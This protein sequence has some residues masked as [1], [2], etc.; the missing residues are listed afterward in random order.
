MKN[1]SLK[2]ALTLSVA[3]LVLTSAFAA[4]EKP[5]KRERSTITSMTAKVEA[6]DKDKREITLKGSSG[7]TI[8]LGVD[9]SV[10]R[11]DEIKVGDSVT[12]DYYVSIA[13]EVREP[14][15]EEKKTPYQELTS[16]GRTPEGTDP[17]AGSFRIIKAV[18][19]VEGLDRPTKSITVK[20]PK[21]NY[22]QVELKDPSILEKLHL[23]DTIMVTYSEG[24]VISL[25][26]APEKDTKD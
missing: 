15:A 1:N 7:N 4:D 9:K 6:V 16:T 14:T 10:K 11:F 3:T 20:G 19:T 21:G 25:D 2:I 13:A 8:T 17:A 26:K 12:A 24:L 23:G 5:L 18:T 22:V